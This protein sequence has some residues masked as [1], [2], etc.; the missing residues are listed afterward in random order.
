MSSKPTFQVTVNSVS[1]DGATG[2]TSVDVSVDPETGEFEM[3]LP[4]WVSDIPK[5]FGKTLQGVVQ[6]YEQACDEFS[7]ERLGIALEPMLMFKWRSEVSSGALAIGLSEQIA[8]G[9]TEVFSD[10]QRVYRRVAGGMG[11][12]LHEYEPLLLDDTPE[13]RAKYEELAESIRTAGAI[14]NDINLAADPT[15]FFLKIAYT[16]PKKPAAEPVQTELPLNT[17]SPTN[18][19]DEEL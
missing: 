11:A 10:G 16:D 7:R 6:T 2:L 12:R 4:T 5:V 8:I 9:I 18:P 17:P 14:F 13:V 3:Q 15:D 1:A 19:E